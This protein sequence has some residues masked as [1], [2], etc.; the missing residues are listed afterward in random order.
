[1]NHQIPKS[2]AYN[3]DGQKVAAIK[4]YFSK[5]EPMHKTTMQK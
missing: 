5:F 1:M 2:H 4:P 3:F